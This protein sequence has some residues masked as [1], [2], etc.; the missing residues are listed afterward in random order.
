MYGSGP[1]ECAYGWLVSGY[2]SYQADG[3]REELSFFGFIW[4]TGTFGLNILYSYPEV[5]RRRAK[6]KHLRNGARSGE[7]W[8]S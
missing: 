6:R 4:G 3:A 1:Y 2:T 5:K 8:N 7:G